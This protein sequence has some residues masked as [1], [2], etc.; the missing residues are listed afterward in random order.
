LVG[1]FFLLGTS[2]TLA[3]PVPAEQEALS[4]VGLPGESQRTARRLIAADKLV[5][6]QK[7]AEAVDEYQRILIEVGDDLVPLNAR[8]SLQARWLCHLRLAALPAAGLRLYRARVD[9]QAK[10]WL[11]QAVAGRDVD[12]LRRLVE[13]LFC[14]S[15]TDQVLDQLG[16]LAFERGQFEEAERWWRMLAL[17]ALQM[18][19]GPRIKD[20]LLFPDPQ[21]DVAGVR[22]KQILAR[23]FRGEQAG[24]LEEWEAFQKLHG[25]AEGYLA[26]KQGNY[27]AILTDLVGQIEMPAQVLENE[28]W[29]TFAGDASRSYIVPRA[30]GRLLRLPQVEGP[31]WR[32]ELE[33]KGKGPEADSERPVAGKVVPPSQAARSLPFYPLIVGDQVL[34]ADARHVMAYELSSGRQVLRYDVAPERNDAELGVTLRLPAAPDLGYPLTAASGRIYAR[35]GAQSLGSRRGGDQESFLVCLNWPSTSGGKIQRWLVNKPPAPEGSV[36]EGSPIVHHGSVYIA[37]ARQAGIQVQTAVAC[38]DAD[39]GALRWQR[40]ICDTQELKDGEARTRH[41]LLTLAADKIVYCSHSGAIVALDATSGRRAW[42]VRYPGRGNRTADRTPS[43]RGL[44]PCVHAKGRLY[45]APLDYDRILCLDATTGHQLWESAPLEVVHLLGVAKGRLIFTTTTP[46]RGIRALDAATGLPQRSWFQPADG[47]DLATFGRGLLAGDYVFWPTRGTN[48]TGPSCVQ[49]RL[50]V[51]SQEDGEP[52]IAPVDN[53][54]G[55]LAAANGCMVVADATS[56]SAYVP[57]ELLLPTRR[58]QVSRAAFGALAGFG[59]LR[60]SGTKYFGL[61]SRD[62]NQ[63]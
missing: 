61:K 21:L 12:L 16:D 25:K 56:L 49:D 27:V 51:L 47:T 8:H 23:L 54:A 58:T 44:A 45:A 34:V 2:T 48:G 9:N 22:A 50:Y 55:N 11:D 36:F 14:S 29:A 1:V 53:I 41:H 63:R 60:P 15:S 20:T 43:P 62:S 33:N 39:T 19:K 18:E 35:L 52:V 31:T 30:G 10:K 17:P 59:A 32:V 5:A 46:R 37:A 3:Q 40:E 24:L 28:V 6:E 42:A 57:D 7:W 4:R 13:E 38:Y 26:G